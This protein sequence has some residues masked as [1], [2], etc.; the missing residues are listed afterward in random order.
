MEDRVIRTTI[1]ILK[2]AERK[3]NKIRRKKIF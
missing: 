3:R 1:Q 2:V